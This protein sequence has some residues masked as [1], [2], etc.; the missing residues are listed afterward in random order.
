MTAMPPPVLSAAPAPRRTPGKTLA[1]A[2]AA[3]AVAAAAPAA[4]AQDWN[5]TPPTMLQWFECPWRDMERRMGDYFVAG[6]GS[7]WLPPIS[8]AYHPPTASNQN[9]FSA[10]YDTFD[11]FD[12]G[13][14]GANTAYGTEAYFR[15][16]VEEFHRASAQVYIDIVLNHNAGRQ[17]GAGFQND[18]GYPGFTMASTTPAVNKLPTDNWGDFHAGI[19]GGYYQSEDPGAAR[20]CLLRGDLVA[21]VDIDQATNLQLIRQPVDAGN[22]LNIPGGTYFNRVDAANRRFYPDA[23]L[24]TDTASN[25]GMFTGAGGFGAAP[26]DVPARNEPASQLTRGRFNQA[27][28]LAGDPVPE[29]GTGY[30]LRW[31]QWM[32]DVHKV[33]GFRVDAI[34]HMNS[35]FYDSFYDTVLANRRLAPSGQWVTPFSFGESVESNDFTFDRFIRKPNGRAAGRSVAGDAYGNRDALDINGSGQLRNLVNGF[36]LGSWNGILG[37][38]IDSTDDGFNNGS[39][40]VNH[41]FSHDNGSQGNGNSAP[42]TPTTK[43]QGHH[44]HAYLIMRTGQAKVFHNARGI[45]RTSGFWPRQGLPVALGS[46]SGNTAPDPT[47]TRL[48]Q[49]ANW[50]GRGEFQPRWTDNDLMIFERRSP[51]GGGAYSGNV[52][53]G[54]NDSYSSGFD[55]RSISTSFPQGTRLLELT[56]N[57]ADPAVD[58][59]NDIADVLVVGAGGSVTIRVPRNTSTAGEHNK[60]FVVYGPAVPSGVVSFTGTLGQLPAENASSGLPP[61]RRRTNAVPIITADLFELRLTTTNG[62]A[63]APN[64]DNA[65]DNAVFRI[66]AGFQDVNGNGVVDIGADNGVVPG[67]ESFLTSNI[68]LAGTTNPTGFYMQTVL[69]SQMDEGTHFVSVA[70]FRRRGVADAPLFREFRQPIYVDRLPPEAELV[71]PGVLSNETSRRFLVRA[72]DRTVSKVHLILNPGATG[73]PLSLAAV[74][75]LATQDDRFDWSRTLVNLQPGDNTVL[76]IAFEESG[77]GMFRYYTITNAICGSTDFDGDGDEGTDADIEAFFSVLGG[78]AC[79]TATCGSTDFDLDGDQGT[80][81]DIESF[82]RAIGGTGC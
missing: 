43:Q 44:A 64:N 57:A 52:I 19:A 37:S 38:H 32:L 76:L 11:R 31:V 49:L 9:S 77:K 56:G 17:T 65:D 40:G 12:L 66:D 58:P 3:G 23:A 61:W 15:Q 60:G 50:Y 30:L 26:C 81:A 51:L 5:E 14:P 75:N 39:I 21:L 72:L 47:I 1:L 71:D 67:Y 22:P 7:V 33:D 78:G 4:L 24:G 68:P 28:P 80:D 82:F 59:V 13:K 10:G 25:P 2:F 8:R 41:I 16:L 69:A 62:D 20:Y 29:N 18:G 55:S 53:V 70:A 34:K 27:D 42:A 6:Y 54:C 73:A 79:P 35:W 48:V 36:G 45:A 63:G 46:N 74:G